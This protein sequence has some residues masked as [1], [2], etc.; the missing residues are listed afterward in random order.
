MSV[1]ARSALRARA[2]A[3]LRSTAVQRRALHVENVV[4]N[5][6]PFKHDPSMRFSF[7]AKLAAFLLTGALLP[8][9]ASAYQLRKKA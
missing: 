8:V 5:A 9:A 3:V 1:L 4:G 6:T 2:P 7:A